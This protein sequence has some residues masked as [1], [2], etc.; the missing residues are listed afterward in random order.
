MANSNT[1]N[2]KKSTVAPKVDKRLFDVI[3]SEVGGGS[4]EE[5]VAVTSVFLNRISTEGYEKAL[6]SSSAYNKQSS[7]YKKAKLG[8]LNSY[9]QKVY[10]RNSAIVN[11]LL[12][13]PTTIVPFTHFENVNAFGEPSWGKGKP[14]K[15]IGRQRFYTI[16]E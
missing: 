2:L 10:L 9:E 5:V 13:N 12:N 8:L 3:Y 6:K 4:P 11:G 1:S 7:E 16:Q 14:Y 15:D